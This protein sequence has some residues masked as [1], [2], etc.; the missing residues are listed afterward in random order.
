MGKHVQSGAVLAENVVNLHKKVAA[1]V[2]SVLLEAAEMGLN[3]E[4][5]AFI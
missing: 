3:G 1:V 2:S 4:G 5:G